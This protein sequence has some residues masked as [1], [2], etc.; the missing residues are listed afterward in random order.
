MS[1]HWMSGHSQNSLCE[2]QNCIS[3]DI[4]QSPD[5]DCLLKKRKKRKEWEQGNQVRTCSYDVVFMYL[6]RANPVSQRAVC[7]T[8]CT[9]C[10]HWLFSWDALKRILSWMTK[11]SHKNSFWKC[12]LAKVP[13]FGEQKFGHLVKDLCPAFFLM[14]RSCKSPDIWCR[15]DQCG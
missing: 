6:Y 14:V 2:V 4:W 13:T 5:M 8:L 3:P 15:L 11:Y 1:G 12:G 10:L 7:L 9:Y